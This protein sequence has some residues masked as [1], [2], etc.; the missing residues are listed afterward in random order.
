[1]TETS[2]PF[3]DCCAAPDE[4][5]SRRDVIAGL[6]G[7][8]ALTL[9]GGT[10]FAASSAF[11][12]EPRALAFRNLHTDETLETI[13]WA[14]GGYRHEALQQ[15]NHILR[16][17]RTGDLQ[18]MDPALLDLL[19]SLKAK[20]DS[21]G[22]FHVISAYRSPKTNAALASKSGGVAR[23]SFHMRGMAIDIALPDH[24]L[25]AL[26]DAAWAMQRGGVGYYAKSGFIHVDT[27]RV[28]RWNF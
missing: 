21:R 19:Y 28:R 20:T 13:Y 11:A 27:G 5:L 7:T 25:T 23:K 8:A 22:P 9:L 24:D 26:R 10:T 16:D 4:G 17:W 6:T 1:M 3:S 14:D 18:E 12:G 15:I 2:P